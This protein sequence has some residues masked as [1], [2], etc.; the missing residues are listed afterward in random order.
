MMMKQ[1]ETEPDLSS[2]AS[3]KAAF[4]ERRPA[5]KPATDEGFPEDP[6]PEEQQSIEAFARFLRGA[7]PIRGRSRAFEGVRG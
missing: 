1:P 3:I 2:V 5:I 4:E 7:I 6:T